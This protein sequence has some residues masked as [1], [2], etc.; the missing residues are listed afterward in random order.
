MKVTYLQALVYTF[1]IV[2]GFMGGG[3]LIGSLLNP[4]WLI[5]Y[6]AALIGFGI[7]YYRYTNEKEKER[8]SIYRAE[9][10]ALKNK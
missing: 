2:G 6:F 8:C 9:K 3:I 10:E 7:W 5:P 1:L 4:I